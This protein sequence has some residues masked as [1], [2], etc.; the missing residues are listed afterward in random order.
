MATLSLAKRQLLEIARGLMVDAKVL[1]L[2]E[3]TATLSDIEI[4]RVH[5]VIKELVAGGHSIVYIT[6]RLGEVFSLADR[7]TIMRAGK[8]AASGPTA[9]FEMKDVVAHMLGADHVPGE[10]RTPSR[11]ETGAPVSL[12]SRG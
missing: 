12:G 6:H 7:I 5:G 3:P 8:V 9:E 10:K 4:E 11:A 1:I 2:D